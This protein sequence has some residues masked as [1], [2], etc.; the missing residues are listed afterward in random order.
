L[1]PAFEIGQ[2][3]LA[4]RVRDA[5]KDCVRLGRGGSCK[6]LHD[7]HIGV[8][9]ESALRKCRVGEVGNGIRPE[10][11]QRIQLGR[12]RS[13]EDLP[14][15]LAGLVENGVAGAQRRVTAHVDH[16]LRTRMGRA[17]EELALVFARERHDGGEHGGLVAPGRSRGPG[18]DHRGT[19]ISHGV[20]G[21]RGGPLKGRDGVGL[22]SRI[23][24]DHVSS[25]GVEGDA[26]GRNHYQLGALVEHRLTQPKV[27]DGKRLLGIGAHPDDR[28]SPFEIVEGCVGARS[29]TH[30]ERE[31]VGGPGVLD[32]RVDVAR[33]QHFASQLR[34][35]ERVLG[36]EMP[37]GDDPDA[38]RALEHLGHRAQGA[39]PR[40]R[41][42]LVPRA[43]QGCPQAIR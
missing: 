5:R 15:V 34:D 35:A 25:E 37:S 24:P 36:G 38:I 43:Q 17:H 26:T 7:H 19:D 4:L 40:D 18:N 41:F 42:E 9:G 29:R 32:A 28:A 8:A 10:D 23:A 3:A 14:G 16:A 11:E 31:L 33:V 30:L 1:E 2:R 22:R 27:E 13:F 21:G 20:G 6:E 39:A 12:G